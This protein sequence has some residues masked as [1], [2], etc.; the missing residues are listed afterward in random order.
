MNTHPPSPFRGGWLWA[1]IGVALLMAAFVTLGF[2]QLGR[3]GQRRAA[4]AQMIARMNEPSLLLDGSP[5]DPQQAN[6]RRAVVRGTYDFGQ[7]IILR[8]R[9]YNELPGVHAI[10]PLRI[11]GS[12]EA[13]LVDRGWIPYELSSPEQRAQ[14]HDVAGEVEVQGILRQSEARLSH[15]SPADPP[16]GPDRPRLD[17]WYR[18]EI[19]RIQEQ[20]PYPLLSMY[21]EEAVG[22]AAARRFPRPDPQIDLSEGPHLGYAIQWFSFAGIVLAGYVLL[23]RQRTQALDEH[24]R[25]EGT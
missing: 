20:V 17:A 2:W 23:Y 19:P 25:V 22:G 1:T 13:V 24:K 9:A 8:N 5:L 10:V 3:L 21:L 14:F 4:N 15:L 12:A 11:V 6:L 7:E 16:L 18:V